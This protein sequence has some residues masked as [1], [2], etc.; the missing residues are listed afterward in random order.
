MD[1]KTLYQEGLKLVEQGK[2]EEAISTFTK[3]KEAAPMYTEILL[4]LGVVLM[5]SQRNAEAIIVFEQARAIKAPTSFSGKDVAGDVLINLGAALTVTKK[6]DEAAKVL[7][8]AKAEYPKTPAVYQ[9]LSA[10]YAARGDQ[11]NALLCIKEGI[12]QT[13]DPELYIVL[14]NICVKMKKWRDANNMLVLAGHAGHK[15]QAMIDKKIK[16][17]RKIIPSDFTV[18]VAGVDITDR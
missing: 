17:I 4:N 18:T 14:A 13:R 3:A 9:N 1:A 8:Q 6:F 2:L 12:K 10:L 5:R 15:D 11:D 16:E 7:G